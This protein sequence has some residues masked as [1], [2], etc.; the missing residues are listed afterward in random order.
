MI[1]PE[2]CVRDHLERFVSL[3]SV[4]W[5]RPSKIDCLLSV[6]RAHWI[7]WRAFMLLRQNPHIKVTRS[8][9]FGS[10]ISTPLMVC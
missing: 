2:N 1:M 6:T 8:T 10:G 4:V 5:P 9:T 3:G 7:K